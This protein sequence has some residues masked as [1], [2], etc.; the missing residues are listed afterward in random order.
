MREIYARLYCLCPISLSR[1]CPWWLYICSQLGFTSIFFFY[2]KSK[3][4]ALWASCILRAGF[5]LDRNQVGKYRG[6]R[7]HTLVSHCA[8]RSLDQ[9]ARSLQRERARPAHHH[10]GSL[11]VIPLLPTAILGRPM[12]FLASVKT[13]VVLRRAARRTRRPCP[14]CRSDGSWTACQSLTLCHHQFNLHEINYFI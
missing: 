12:H 4:W 13:F 14:Y 2:S 3:C 5:F 1:G 9:M 6:P 10:E 11:L 7:G 8:R